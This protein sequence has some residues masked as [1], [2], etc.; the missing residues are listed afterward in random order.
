[1]T[2]NSNSTVQLLRVEEV[3]AAPRR[4]K[5]ETPEA[6]TAPAPI[7]ISSPETPKAEPSK[8]DLTLA[9]LKAGGFALSARALLL[10]SLIGAFVLALQAMASQSLASMEILAIYGAFTILPV[11]YLETR[12]GRQ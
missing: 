3:P 11:A 1:M 12:R 2:S 10:L 7:L 8:L 9:V 6:P 5:P 4:P